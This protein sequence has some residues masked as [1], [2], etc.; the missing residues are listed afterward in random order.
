MAVLPIQKNPDN[1]ILR[2][3]SKPV[4]KV[5][6]KLLKFLDDMRETMFDANGIGLA[7]PQVG[8][9]IRVVVCYFNHET[10]NELIVDMI[11]PEIISRSEKMVLNEEGCLSLPG[12]FDKVRRHASLVVKYLDRKGK[13]R[14]LQLS[15]L[16]ARIVQHEIDHIDGTLY[17]DRVEKGSI[18]EKE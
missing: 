7:A 16:N 11:N 8:E 13:E 2:T 3:V 5:D 10:P 4:K 14:V 15:G 12:E 18:L 1:E 6:K 17:I 9:N